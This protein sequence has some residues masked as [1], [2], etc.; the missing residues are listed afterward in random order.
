MKSCPKLQGVNERKKFHKNMSDLGP[1]NSMFCSTVLELTKQENLLLISELQSDWIDTSKTRGQL[2]IDTS[3]YKVNEYSRLNLNWPG[4]G[5]CRLRFF[6]A[7]SG[8][9][10]F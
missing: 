10:S 8:V 5:C 9:K 6:P 2:Y 1:K 4:R 3:P 7:I